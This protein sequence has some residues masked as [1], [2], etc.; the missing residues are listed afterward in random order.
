MGVLR[1]A[2][3]SQEFCFRCHNQGHKSYQCLTRSLHMGEREEEPPFIS[4][5]MDPLAPPLPQIEEEAYNATPDLTQ[6][7]QEGGFIGCIWRYYF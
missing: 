6:E 5:L 1:Q 3:S 2:S 7:F 4:E